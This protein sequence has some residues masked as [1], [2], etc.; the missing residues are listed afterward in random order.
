MIRR[1]VNLRTFFHPENLLAD[2][3]Q[4]FPCLQAKWVFN[5]HALVWRGL[6]GPTRYLK[7]PSPPKKDEEVKKGCNPR[8]L[9]TPTNSLHPFLAS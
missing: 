3:N 5:M 8:L 6:F 4:L 1:Y 9:S 7:I 2:K